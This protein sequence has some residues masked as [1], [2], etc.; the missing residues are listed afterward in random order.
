MSIGHKVTLHSRKVGYI[1][2]SQLP[3]N[4]WKS[5]N[6]DES[7][8]SKIVGKSWGEKAENWGRVGEYRGIC[9][10]W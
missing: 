10:L 9:H 3:L 7:G 5:V 4:D 8:K 6:V 2:K 1:L